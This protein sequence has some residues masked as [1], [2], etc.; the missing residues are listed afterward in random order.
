MGHVSSFASWVIHF[1]SDNE[2]PSAEKLLQVFNFVFG[3]TELNPQDYRTLNRTLALLAIKLQARNAEEILD[4]ML[5]ENA[6]HQSKDFTYPSLDDDLAKA[7]GPMAI[8]LF[9]RLAQVSPKP[10]AEMTADVKVR[11]TR[12]LDAFYLRAEAL[13]PRD[14]TFRFLIKARERGLSV[15]RQSNRPSFQLGIG[16]NRSLISNGFTNFTSQIATN[17]SS[18]K[19]LASAVLFNAGFPVPQHLI[20]DSFPAAA[21]AAK[22]IGFPVVVKPTSTDKG[23][24]VFI[25]VDTL[26]E[27]AFAFDRASRYGNVLIEQFLNGFDHRFH[28]V[29]GKCLY[30]TQRIPPYVVGN[31]LD[32]IETLLNDSLA[33]RAKNPLYLV[34]AS[35]SLTD[36]EVSRQLS[37]RGYTGSTVLSKGETFFL[38]HNANVSTGGSYEIVTNRVHADNISLAERAARIVGLDNAGVDFISRDASKSW[39]D[40]GGGICEINATPG[41]ADYRSFD[42][43]LDYLFPNSSDGRI[44]VVLSVKSAEEADLVS[45][46]LEK[47][48]TETG[49]SWGAIQDKT[50]RVKT[51]FGTYVGRKSSLRESMFGLVSDPAVAVAFISVNFEDLTQGI[52]LDYFSLIYATGL[53]DDEF[54]AL[55]IFATGRCDKSK[56]VQNPSLALVSAEATRLLEGLVFTP[57]NF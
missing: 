23:V 21:K 45:I 3:D 43:Q 24:A 41:T 44:P 57:K 25:G 55:Q 38:R 9:A 14:D 6:I 30:V 18:H 53:S 22:I 13:A 40:A 35:A 11:I 34:Y 28:V 31:G 17:I 1:E 27:L 54:A 10:G 5:R 16:A 12:I 42:K 50:L 49:L 7:V 8:K 47:T 46:E 52:E 4:W 19:P 48:F 29:N 51:D 2:T 56:I 33:E 32:S 20:V 15:R 36:P 26:D 37:K 39:K